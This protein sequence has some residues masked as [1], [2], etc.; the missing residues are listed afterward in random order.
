MTITSDLAADRIRYA[1]ETRGRMACAIGGLFTV[2][3]DGVGEAE[4]VSQRLR[5]QREASRLAGF[6]NIARLCQEMDDC[7]A[8]ACRE[9]RPRLKAVA[10]TLIDNCRSIQLHADAVAQGV[11]HLTGDCFR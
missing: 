11:V 4:T 9:G 3:R 2:G 6:A 1:S 8:E 7:L 5:E 10:P